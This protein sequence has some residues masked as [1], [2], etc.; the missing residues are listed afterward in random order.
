MLNK[1]IENVE[2]GGVSMTKIMEAN[3]AQA[4]LADYPAEVFRHIVG[5]Q[6][7]AHLVHADVIQIVP[8]VS[9]FKQPPI[10]CLLRFLRC[11]QFPKHHLVF[12]DESIRRF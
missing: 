8:A 11:Q 4:V 5:P 7:L 12:H 1:I 10:L 6:E 2:G 3:L 9:T